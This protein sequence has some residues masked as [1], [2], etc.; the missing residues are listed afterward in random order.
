MLATSIIPFTACKKSP[1]DSGPKQSTL[2]K[3]FFVINE[4]NFTVGNSSLSFYSY[5]SSNMTNNLFYK[6]NGVPLGDVATSISFHRN[7][8]FIVVNNSGSIYIVDRNTLDFISSISELRSPRHVHIVNAER[9]YI[10]DLQD[11]RLTSFN[12][13]NMEFTGYIPLGKTSENMLTYQNKL[14]VTNWSGFY[15]TTPNNT[16]QVVDWLSNQLID[17]IVVAREPNSMVMDLN[18]KLW[19]LCSGGFMGEETPALYRINPQ[20]HSIEASFLFDDDTSS[21]QQLAINGTA[22]TLY[23]LNNGIFRMSVYANVLPMNAFIESKHRNFYML[24]VEP[25][26]SQLLVTDPLNYIQDGFVYRFRADGTLIDS[27]SAGIIP[28]QIRFN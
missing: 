4:G 19:V 24:A 17:S 22:D 15:Q 9:A 21:P 20:D 7:L 12:P 16:V 14:F 23:F 1:D 25:R 26:L 3:G 13:T 8:A 5:D 6:I 10:S 18:S 28:G 11:D 27:I 2:G